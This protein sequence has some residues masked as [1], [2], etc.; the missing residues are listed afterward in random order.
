MTSRKTNPLSKEDIVA[1]DGMRA[2]FFLVVTL[3]EIPE[4]IQLWD[5]A[6]ESL[7]EAIELLRPKL[8]QRLRSVTPEAMD[9]VWVSPI[10]EQ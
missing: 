1:I 5:R 3:C 2:K 7:T 6:R 8:Q 9:N 4:F 10:T